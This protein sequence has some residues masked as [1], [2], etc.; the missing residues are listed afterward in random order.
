MNAVVQD[1]FVSPVVYVQ[2]G[3]VWLPIKMQ[4]NSIQLKRDKVNKVFEYSF[5]FEYIN[6]IAAIG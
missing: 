2:E 3:D 5:E 1:L 4:A 6:P